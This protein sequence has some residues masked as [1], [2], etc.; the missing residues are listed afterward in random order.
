MGWACLGWDKD[1]T[2]TAITPSESRLNPPAPNP[3]NPT[4]TLTYSLAQNGE[5]T[6][7]VYDVRGREAARLVE[8]Y[9]QAGVY[10]V[11]FDGNGLASGVY[12]ARLI[13]GKF[14]QT[15]KLVL[16]K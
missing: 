9:Q 6:L 7:V 14:T 8:G 12:F 1:E 13:A 10:E 16:M 3:F 11:N 5:V 15:Q 4:T 2:I